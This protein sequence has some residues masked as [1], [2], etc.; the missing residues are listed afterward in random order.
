MNEHTKYCGRWIGGATLAIIVVWVLYLARDVLWP[1]VLAVILVYV[2]SPLVDALG[3]RRVPRLLATLCVYVLFLALLV[4]LIAVLAPQL[5][6]SLQEVSEQ[7]PDYMEALRG[8][9]DRV[10]TH[11]ETLGLPLPWEEVTRQLTSRL[12]GLASLI[13]DQVTRLIST[14]F[15][16]FLS[17]VFAL[18]LLKD[19][20][21]LRRSILGYIPY[22]YREPIAEFAAQIDVI[23]GGF[24]R[25]QLIVAVFVGIGIGVGL[26]LLGVP[27]ASI[28]GIVAG[29]FNV[30]PYLGPVI[31]I[32]PAFF[33]AVTASSFSPWVFLWIILLFVGVNQLEGLFLAPHILGKQVRLHPA[34]VIFAVVVGGAVFGMLGLLLAIPVVAVAKAGFIQLR[35]HYRETPEA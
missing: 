10:Q 2:L 20:P 12:G 25:G 29:I 24:I 34:A 18:Y 16:F 8:H 31:A 3:S 4:L 19:G 17:L 21:R 5:A 13:V 35:R 7:L 33:F 6:L 15:L 27:H 30:I 11:Y 14:L 1:F 23:L 26:F 22:R 28:L 9:I 32:I